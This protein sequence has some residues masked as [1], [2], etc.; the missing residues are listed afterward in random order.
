[1]P[2]SFLDK[3]RDLLAKVTEV[4]SPASED[5]A[6][7]F[8]EVNNMAYRWIQ[9][10][11]RKEMNLDCSRV[12]C[13]ASTAITTFLHENPAE[14][15]WLA[16]VLQTHK[17]ENAYYNAQ[18][19]VEK[20]SN[21]IA[22]VATGGEQ[23]CS[24][25]AP[26]SERQ[27]RTLYVTIAA[28]IICSNYRPTVVSGN[29]AVTGCR[30]GKFA[31]SDMMALM[32]YRLGSAATDAKLLQ[33]TDCCYLH[34]QR[35]HPILKAFA[36]E[37]GV[38]GFR[39]M[40][41]LTVAVSDFYDCKYQFVGAW[42]PAHTSHLASAF[43]KQSHVEAGLVA[44]SGAFDEFSESASLAIHK[45]VSEVVCEWKTKPSDWQE[46]VSFDDLSEE[47]NF[48]CRMFT[49]PRLENCPKTNLVIRNAAAALAQIKTASGDPAE[50][51]NHLAEQIQT[52]SNDWSVICHKARQL[53]DLWP[54]Q[55]NE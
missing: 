32:G 31:E 33:T 22:L 28:G 19:P 26:G 38:L 42:N 52:I 5:V 1:M 20:T 49:T 23:Q 47:V 7:L 46:V 11:Q 4:E 13:A 15:Y 3:A 9:N 2:H 44:S 10:D 14:S 18:I 34:L 8:S 16:Q 53:F 25:I 43:S 37:R 55:K 36:A 24:T 45:G 35:Y 50:F 40:M 54:K 27:C 30:C 41:K 17:K 6:A 48:L 12:F 21:A 51:N 29:Y 39:D